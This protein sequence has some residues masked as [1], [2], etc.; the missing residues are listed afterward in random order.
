MVLGPKGP[1]RV[2]RRRAYSDWGRFK[3][4]PNRVPINGSDEKLM[5]QGENRSEI[6]RNRQGRKAHRKHSAPKPNTSATAK[7]GGAKSSDRP[8]SGKARVNSNS[9]GS[10]A[11]RKPRRDLK[12]AARDLPRW[13][14]DDLVR[15]TPEART[16]AALEALGSASSAFASGQYHTAA[17]HAQKA[18]ALS[19]RD[20]TIRETLGLSS[21]RIGDWKTGLSELRTY[22]RLTGE[23]THLPVEMDCLRALG[24]PRAIENSWVELNRRKAKPAVLKEGLVVY[25]SFLIDVGEAERAYALAV[26]KQIRVDASDGEHRVWYVAARAAALLGRGEEASALRNAILEQDPSFPGIDDLE[27]LISAA[28]QVSED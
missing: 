22:R 11:K 7:K 15:V 4:G 25:A 12:G 21:Y 16:P 23:T 13:V 19:S 8:Y 10:K 1:G 18:K 27:S 2:G 17:K 3:S 14:V 9:R 24:Q 5:A 20:A 28:L 6:N 26:P